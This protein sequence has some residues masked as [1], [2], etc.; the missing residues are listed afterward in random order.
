MKGLT[1]AWFAGLAL[2]LAL[3]ASAAAEG[4]AAPRRPSLAEAAAGEVLAD[5]DKFFAEANELALSDPTRARELYG[6]AALKFEYLLEQ[7]YTNGRFYG[8]LANTYF[9]AGDIGR[10]VLNYRRALRFLP[11]DKEL[12]ESLAYVRTQRVDL[13]ILDDV[14]RIKRGIFFWHYHLGDRARLFLFGGAYALL[15][16]FAG[17]RLFA[18]SAG[19]ALSLR[20]ASVSPEPLRGHGSVP[21]QGFGGSRRICAAVCLA[22]GIS[23]IVHAVSGSDR[24]AGV[25]VVAEVV[26]RKGDGYIY[27][28]AL[29]NALHGGVE[30][31]L[32]ENRGEWIHALF[33]NGERAWV[34]V[35]SVAFVATS[36]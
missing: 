29:T 34:P 8:N 35:G 24:R 9:L 36:L 15:W 21:G 11:G 12:T 23:I 31:L 1:I 20:S 7:G 13:F 16:V 32:V 17:W 30:F 22:V 6:A 14:S 33:D 3:S 27:E 25:I 28:P 19:S 10:S 18:S 26:A 2:A 5:A 4:D